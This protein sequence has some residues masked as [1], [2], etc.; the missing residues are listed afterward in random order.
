MDWYY[1]V[2]G[3]VTTFIKINKNTPFDPSIPF[4]EIYLNLPNLS[5]FYLFILEYRWIL[6]DVLSVKY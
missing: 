4:L 3:N 1:S 2:E 5:K 6:I